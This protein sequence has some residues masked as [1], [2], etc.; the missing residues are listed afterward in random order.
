MP[1]K[2]EKE[3]TLPLQGF[4]APLHFFHIV[5]HSCDQLCFLTVFE[6]RSYVSGEE[7]Q[8]RDIRERKGR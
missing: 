5:C 6:R 4:S 2:R 1:F 3:R 8:V 7:W